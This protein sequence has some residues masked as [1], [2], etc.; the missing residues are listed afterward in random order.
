MLVRS[1]GHS[2]QTIAVTEYAPVVPTALPG[3][4]LSGHILQ[5]V[6][7]ANW[8]L[9]THNLARSWPSGGAVDDTPEMF[10]RL[11]ARGGPRL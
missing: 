5:R 6:A 8:C 7:A 3:L 4:T 11:A 2:E 10:G 9:L 1:T